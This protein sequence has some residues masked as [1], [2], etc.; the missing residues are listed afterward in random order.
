[1]FNSYYETIFYFID[2]VFQ[3]TNHNTKLD[4]FLL[5][6]LELFLLNIL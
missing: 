2:Y 5:L 6:I 1:M 3:G 4:V